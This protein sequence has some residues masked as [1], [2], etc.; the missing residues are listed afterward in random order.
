MPLATIKIMRGDLTFN[1]IDGQNTFTEISQ[2]LNAINPGALIISIVALALLI[3]WE[4]PFMKKIKIF[5]IIQ[6]PLVVVILGIVM[7]LIFKGTGWAL[8]VKQIVAI[9]VAE[10]IGAFFSQFSL[11]KFSEWNNPQV[12]TV[13]LTLA[14][15]SSIETLLCMEATD[16][17]DPFKR[18]SPANREFKGT[19]DRQSC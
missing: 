10:N 9:P 14:T 12:W 19:R 8:D 16:K 15:I 1:Q 5:R 4:R 11:P 13:A 17:L 6:G 7:Q 18:V 2:M 3:L